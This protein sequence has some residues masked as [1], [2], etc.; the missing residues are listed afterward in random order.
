MTTQDIKASSRAEL[1]QIRLP[2][3]MV[4]QVDALARRDSRS[5]SGLLR[6]ITMDFL[7]ANAPAGVENQAIK[8]GANA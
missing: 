5:R 2:P 1:I 6:K 8:P 7:Q 3:W 4:E